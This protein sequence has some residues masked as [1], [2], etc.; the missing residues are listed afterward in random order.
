MNPIQTSREIRVN[1]AFRQLITTLFIVTLIATACATSSPSGHDEATAVPTSLATAIASSTMP[2]AQ[3]P[4][5]PI[6]P[7]ATPQ[8][9]D[10]PVPPSSTPQPSA[11]TATPAALGEIAVVTNIVD[12]DTI[13][14]EMDG[15]TYRVRYIGID[16][17]EMDQAC[18][19]EA[20]QANAALV[21]G[22]TVRMVKDVSET[23]RFGRLLRYVYV[24]DI[25][26]NGALVA[27]GWA[28][29]KDYPPDVA[30]S[31]LLHDLM[32]EGIGRGCELV[33]GAQATPPP[34]SRGPSSTA[35]RIVDVNKRA[36]YVDLLNEGE[37]DVDLAGWML[38]SERG[39]QE[40]WLR[41]TIGAGQTL[42]VWA[43]ARDVDK[44]G[45]NCGFSAEIW[46]NSQP[47]PA[48]LFDPDGREVSRFP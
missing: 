8:P 5:T 7:T 18:G 19:A 1:S 3:P 14:V 42:R 43:V 27:G 13:D 4:D 46:N 10:T 40:C 25:F 21:A 22:Q 11:P 26:V 47:D 48:V 6:V 28:I 12:G 38:L 44:G 30:Q 32:L 36:E 17:P 15:E 24:D 45:F 37:A 20:K 31:G 34:G 16:T 33:A 9:T 2:T 29:A 41:G 35:L 39:D 23:D